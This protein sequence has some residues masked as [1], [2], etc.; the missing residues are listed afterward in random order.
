[1]EVRYPPSK[2]VSQRYL[3]DTLKN[4]AKGCDTPLCDSI[5]KRY[6][7]IRGG[8][9]HWAAKLLYGSC[10]QQIQASVQGAM[11]ERVFIYLRLSLFLLTVGLCCLRKVCLVFF[12]LWLNSVWYFLLMVENSIGLVFFACSSPLS[13]VTRPNQ[14]AGF[15]RIG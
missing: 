9:S 2:G 3:R 1:M 6:C 12:D 14:F 10:G 11:R 4:K 15:A 5:S 7:A 8:I 13:G